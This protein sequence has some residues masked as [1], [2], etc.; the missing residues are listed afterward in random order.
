MT[1]KIPPWASLH[2]NSNAPQNSILSS[3]KQ[4][5]QLFW[6]DFITSKCEFLKDNKLKKVLKSHDL[7]S[8]SLKNEF[9]YWYAYFDMTSHSQL[10][11]FFNI[12]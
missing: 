10:F 9:L 5:L 3:S 12:N 2:T 6:H 11:K 8:G 1:G 4:G 7:M